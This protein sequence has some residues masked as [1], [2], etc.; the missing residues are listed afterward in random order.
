[1]KKVCTGLLALMFVLVA[2]MLF[3][4]TKSSKPAAPAVNA[5]TNKDV[6]AMVGAGLSTD[7]V[8]A[9][10]R[11]AKVKR[12]NT[13]ATGLIELKKANVPDEVIKAMMGLSA[14]QKPVRAVN[15]SPPAEAQSEPRPARNTIQHI[16]IS[17]EQTSTQSVEGREAGIYVEVNGVQVQL[18]PSVYTG[19]KSGNK[20]LHSITSLVKGS[21]KVVVRS[22]HAS[23]RVNVD[24]PVFYF[25]FENRSAG[26]SNTAG[27]SATLNGASSPNEFVLVKMEVSR[28][29]RGF[30]TSESWT[31]SDRTGVRSKD[32]IDFDIKKLQPGVYRVT[33]RESMPPGEYCFFYAL[34]ATQTGGGKIFDFGVDPH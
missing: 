1:M 34:A 3:A 25:Y 30:I 13:T 17:Q 16:A 18:E 10:I 21:I 26:L 32:T 22:A 15:S 28:D 11:E 24:K 19:G 8:V 20:F 23:Q 14:D 5:M 2:G 33:P 4:Q 6:V 12:F 27:A 31:F 29:E 7:V 9:A